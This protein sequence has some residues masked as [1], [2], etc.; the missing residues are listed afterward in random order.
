MKRRK[1]A[2]ITM[3]RATKKKS[4]EPVMQQFRFHSNFIPLFLSLSLSTDTQPHTHTHIHTV[5]AAM[6]AIKQ[7]SNNQEKTLLHLMPFLC[8]IACSH[9]SRTQIC[10]IFVCSL[11]ISVECLYYL[12]S[13]CVYRIRHIKNMHKTLKFIRFSRQC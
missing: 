3:L 2:T 4:S 12:E 10:D 5:C 7:M 8:R 11:F 1:S 9:K 6:D 13:Y